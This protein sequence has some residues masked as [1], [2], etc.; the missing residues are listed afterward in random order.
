MTKLG[1]NLLDYIK[2]G[3]VISESQPIT[4]ITNNNINLNDTNGGQNDLTTTYGIRK[5]L[6]DNYLTSA[7][8]SDLFKVSNNIYV[9]DTNGDD[10]T[11]MKG[12]INKSYKTIEA[13]VSAATVGDLIY[14]F[15]D[16]YTLTTTSNNGIAKDGV[17]FN[18]ENGVN[19]IKNTNNPIFA[20]DNTFT[21]GCNVYGGCNFTRSGGT[22][23]LIYFDN[24]N[25]VN[26]TTFNFNN[27]ISLVDETCVHIENGSVKINGEL[28]KT[29]DSKTINNVNG[30][31]IVINIV[32]VENFSTTEYTFYDVASMSTIFIHYLIN[33]AL[34]N[35]CY[36]G[37]VYG[38]KNL[39]IN[40]TV[41]VLL[42][43]VQN[44]LFNFTYIENLTIVGYGNYIFNG[45]CSSI[46]DSGTTLS[47]ILYNGIIYSNYIKYNGGY[48]KLNVNINEDVSTQTFEIND[49]YLILDG[50]IEN[51]EIFFIINGGKV[52]IK[53][54]INSSSQINGMMMINDG[55]VNILNDVKSYNETIVL[56]NGILKINNSNIESTNNDVL[57]YE[58][59]ITYINGST[60][61]PS[62]ITKYPISNINID[63]NIKILSGGLTINKETFTPRSQKINVSVG[64]TIE[65]GETYTINLSGVNYNVSGY[66]TSI[67]V[68]SGLS[69]EISSTTS[70][71]I[72]TNNGNNLDIEYISTANNFTYSTSKTAGTGTITS[73]LIRYATFPLT[74]ITGGIIIESD[75]I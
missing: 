72:L 49:G 11:A 66:T 35:L 1:K 31:E 24:T 19:V 25:I 14:V 39:N 48:T 41:S 16:D 2:N 12:Y 32:K 57:I 64:G 22:G 65:S 45:N 56:K 29:L 59:G 36:Y 21:I 62:D 7:E 23:N 30:Q 69:Y 42:E 71:Y 46:Y 47:H 70:N 6:V 50:L 4:G 33:G 34:G 38:M 52:D 28:C 26:G 44:V 27:I 18:F 74:N 8:T 60:L 9:S 54:A 15:S 13:A 63:K 51:T 5:T 43:N 40:N 10:L 61:K 20:T 3:L 58:S 73:N 68:I 75:E 37:G 55:V 67:D 53:T 17:D